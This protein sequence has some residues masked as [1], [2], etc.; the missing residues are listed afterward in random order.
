MFRKFRTSIQRSEV[1][2]PL[3]EHPSRIAGYT[4]N[5]R[6]RVMRRCYFF[7]Q[8]AKLASTQAASASELGSGTTAN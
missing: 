5:S 1:Q 2:K 7:F 3:W 6:R 4:C 8:P